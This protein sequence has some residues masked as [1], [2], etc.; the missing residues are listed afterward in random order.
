MNPQEI[1]HATLGELQLQMT[2]ATFDTWVRPTYAI[3]YDNGSMVVGVH[4]PYAKEW[5]ENRLST[6][7]HRTLTGILGRSA[8]VRYVVKDQKSSRERTDPPAERTT[9]LLGHAQVDEREPKREEPATANP[10]E[11]DF[12]GRITRPLNPKY[13]FET[14]IVGNSNRLAHA[15]ALAVAEHLGESYNPLFLYGGTGLGKTH[16]LHALGQH[17]QV[18]GKRVMYVSSETFANDL[19]NSIRNQSTEEFRQLYR[20]VDVL[21]IDDIQ[22]IGGKESTQEEFFHT[23]NHLHAANKQIVISSDRHP[24][25]ISTLEDRVRS[26]FEGGMITDIQPPDLEMR[27]AILR[28]KVESH[29]V[30]VPS[31]VL[32]FIARKVQSNIRELEG[33]LTRVYGHAQLMKLPLTVDLAEIVLQ[34]ILRHQP[35]TEAQVIQ[36]VAEFYRVDLADLTGRGR[37]KE[38]V[39]PRQMA[40]YLLREETDASL[41]QIGELLGGRDHTTVMYAYE[42]IAEQIETDNQRRREVLAIKE[43]LYN[44]AT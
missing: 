26:R 28:A 34:D 20:Q 13:T 36:V 2:K 35:I 7:I 6:T 10:R 11:T 27:I 15:A 42:K 16:L 39:V 23:F 24:R 29:S 25:A 8:E 18:H 12:A 31:E 3:G 17:P 32:D 30:A 19:I 21:L 5:L 40:M 22:F 41:P 14:F 43:R 4:S 44:Q 38:I 1:W 9:P 37:N 33:A